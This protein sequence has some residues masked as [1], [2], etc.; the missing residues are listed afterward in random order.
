MA[1]R[2]FRCADTETRFRRRRFVRFARFADV[3][4]PALRELEPFDLARG[5]AIDRDR[6]RL[7]AMAQAPMGYR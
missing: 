6:S 7:G 1:V 4:R 2:S 3:E 5:E